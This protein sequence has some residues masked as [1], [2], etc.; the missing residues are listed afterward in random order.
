MTR[1]APVLAVA[2]PRSLA[3]ALALPA[4][5]LCMAR[6]AHACAMYIPP[7]EEVV[8]QAPSVR[9]VSAQAAA[10]TDLQRAMFLID[11]VGLVGAPVASEESES[12]TIAEV[13]E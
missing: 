13:A 12:Q 4:A 6:P 7:Q 1:T 5:L 2:F 10:P 3:L 11:A 8:V 9:F